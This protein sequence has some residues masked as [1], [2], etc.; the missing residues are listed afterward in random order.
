MKNL[1]YQFSTILAVVIN[2]QNKLFR[3][4]PTEMLKPL[5][6]KIEINFILQNK[7]TEQKPT[8]CQPL[9]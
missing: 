5:L 1:N 4:F 9:V 2:N 6:L 3:L 8:L 7:I